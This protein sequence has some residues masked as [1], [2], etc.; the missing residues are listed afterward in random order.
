MDKKNILIGILAALVVVCGY[1]ALKNQ[2]DNISSKNNNALKADIYPPSPETTGAKTN[3]NISI[4]DL[5][6]AG[7]PVTC[8]A[9][10]T[11]ESAGLNQEVTI[12]VADNRVRSISKITSAEKKYS[13]NIITA[14][15]YQYIWPLQDSVNKGSKINIATITKEIPVA[16]QSTQGFGLDVKLKLDCSPWTANNEKFN[17]PAEI[18]FEDM[19]EKTKE[20]LEIIV[21]GENSAPAPA[22]QE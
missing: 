12:F 9:L 11:E 20:S 5:I 4:N 8:T 6:A 7:N 13:E 15:G 10:I 14:D 3:T 22:P 18:V 19:S 17:I 16:V 21:S 2:N 1:F